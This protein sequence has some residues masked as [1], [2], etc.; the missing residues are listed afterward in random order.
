MKKFIKFAHY[1]LSVVFIIFF[2]C[3]NGCV[4][5]IKNKPVSEKPTT[6]D[7]FELPHRLISDY[8]GMKE[9]DTVSWIWTKKGFT[10]QDC[11]SIKVYPLKNFSHSY[12][13]LAE[14]KLEKTFQEIFTPSAINKKGNIAA[15]I[16]TAIVEMK[17]EKGFFERFSSSIDSNP[18]IEIEIVMFDETSKTVLLKLC[19]S[20]KSDDF[21]EALQ[22]IIKDF[23]KFFNKALILN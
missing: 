10:M 23:E 20:K 11:K 14:K 4:K 12:S 7:M 1:P 2:L 19:H 18:Y 8:D 17:P 3:L 21:N 22:G 16:A 13:L 15:G 6:P 9:N 5:G